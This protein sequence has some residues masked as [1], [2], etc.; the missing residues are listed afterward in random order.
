MRRPPDRK[1]LFAA[2]A[3]LAAL[4]SAWLSPTPLAAQ[5]APAA[6]LAAKLFGGF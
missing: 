4:A 6:A 1:M 5:P 2:A 3:L